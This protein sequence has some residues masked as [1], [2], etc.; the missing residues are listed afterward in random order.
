MAR[1]SGSE[2]PS[3]ADDEK[4]FG[5]LI[6]RVD[7]AIAFAATFEPGRFEGAETRSIELKFPQASFTFTGK[8][9]L[10]GFVVPNFYFHATA[11]YAILRHNGVALGKRDFLGG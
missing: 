4:S 9:Y 6:A 1:L 11:A 8:D 3:W 7:K 10:Y 2:V 5:D